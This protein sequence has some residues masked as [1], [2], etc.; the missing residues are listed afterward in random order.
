M[1]ARTQFKMQQK[2]FLWSCKAIPIFS[3][4]LAHNIEDMWIIFSFGII[5]CS[6]PLSRALGFRKLS[7]I[8]TERMQNMNGA[9]FS[10]RSVKGYS[11][12][13]QRNQQKAWEKRFSKG[14]CKAWIMKIGGSSF[15]GLCLNN[16]QLFTQVNT[17]RQ[18]SPALPQCRNALLQPVTASYLLQWKQLNN[19]L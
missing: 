4:L 17:Y 13:P 8:S 11:K 16:F 10:D 12:P 3:A 5:F 7:K 9:T 2:P 1:K 6:T 19:L 15:R 14:K 18:C